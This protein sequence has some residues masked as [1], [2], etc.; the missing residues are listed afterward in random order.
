MR[1]REP[2]A[3]ENL[4]LTWWHLGLWLGLAV[5]ARGIPL[6]ACLRYND[7]AG[8]D[9]SGWDRLGTNSFLIARA[10]LAARLRAFPTIAAD[11]PCHPLYLPGWLNSLAPRS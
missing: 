6:Q 11:P 5:V 1:C 8:T 4:A 3:D 10:T 2:R 7:V 9:K